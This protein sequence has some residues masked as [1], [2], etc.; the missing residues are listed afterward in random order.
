MDIKAYLKEEKEKIDRQLARMISERFGSAED[1]NPLAEPMAYSL[2]AGGKRLRPILVVTSFRACSGRGEDVYPAACAIECI[3]TYTLIH[4]DLPVMDDDDF[5][6]G[7]P[8]CH[9]RFG[10][11]KAMLAGVGLLL[12]A[13]KELGK[14]AELLGLS[15]R[16]RKELISAVA[17]MVV[18]GGGIGGQVMDLESERKEIS[19]ETLH[20]IHSHK[21]GALFRVS[22]EL[23]G[24]LARADKPELEA[25]ATYGEK[26]GFAF[27]IVDD[28]LDIEGDFAQLGKDVGS[29]QAR[30]K[31]TFPRRFGVEESRLL[32]RRAVEEA[33]DALQRQDL[34]KD[35]LLACLADFILERTS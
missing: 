34:D 32:A 8:T 1:E 27:Q 20:Y 3:H 30:G 25:L 7:L 15:A 18:G 22:C 13:F 29:D 35:R 16:E 24:R 11:R 23:G 14:S 28:L 33:K 2:N 4:D 10:V 5:R 31:A 17:A 9:R 12:A 6:R 19:D 26:I 21:T